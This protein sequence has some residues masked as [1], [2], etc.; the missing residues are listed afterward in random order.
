MEITEILFVN[1]GGY[2]KFFPKKKKQGI[3]SAI[4]IASRLKIAKPVR[5][6]RKKDLEVIIDGYKFHF[7]DMP[8]LRKEK[9]DKH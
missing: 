8:L 7:I 5:E 6:L 4:R 3:R 1:N 2:M 9:N